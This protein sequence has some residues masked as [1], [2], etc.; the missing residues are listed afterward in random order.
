MKNPAN[1]F[2]AA[3]KAGRPQIG[4]WNGLSGSM[5]TE[6]LAGCGFD[7]V[8]I[9]TEHSP[10]E[11]SDALQGLQAIA[12]YPDVSAIVRPAAN[13]TVLI[14]RFL[15]IGA[16]T[17]LLPYI[18]TADAARAAVRA[19]RYGPR[20]IRGVSGMTR[21]TRFGGV[22]NYAASADDELCLLL[23]TETIGALERIEEIAT[24]D[25]VDGIF[26]GPSDLAAS[27]G[28][29]G[30]GTH[31][32]V[33]EAVEG[34]IGKM[35]AMGMPVGILTPDAAFTRRCIDL[36]TTFTAVGVDL[37]LLAEGARALAASFR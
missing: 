27:M 33:M 6:L 37:V 15:D 26:I 28:Y 23:Q 36:G 9:D 34:A 18:E 1:L 7:W 5:A 29:P 32:E 20:G 24:V 35:V 2:K 12:G 21:A 30:Q 4:I 25:G 22:G 16:Q 10:I 31:P 19:M 17:L 3:L 13:D 8:L 14:K 11:V